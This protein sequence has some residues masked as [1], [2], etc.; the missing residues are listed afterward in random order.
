VYT[1]RQG[2][3]K[4]PRASENAKKSSG[5]LPRVS[6]QSIAGA[7]CAARTPS[8]TDCIQ[9]DMPAAVAEVS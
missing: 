5:P 2:D 6:K 7:A 9:T 1:L 4:P 3:A 8:R